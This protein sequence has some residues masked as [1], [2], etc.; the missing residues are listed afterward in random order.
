MLSARELKRHYHLFDHI[1]N[2]TTEETWKSI[3]KD[4]SDKKTHLEN[5]QQYLDDLKL[6]FGFAANVDLS[7]I[8]NEIAS[9]TA[10]LVPLLSGSG[11]AKM[12]SIC[13]D[14]KRTKRM[15]R[16]EISNILVEF[17]I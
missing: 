8:D 13:S 17:G 11:I 6:Q 2:T 5:F 7:G 9:M 1:R 10:N 12:N 3:L 14:K 4:L 16:V 15:E